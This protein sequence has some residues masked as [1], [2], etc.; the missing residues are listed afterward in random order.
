MRLALAQIKPR[1]RDE[2]LGAAA[3]H[4]QTLI[5][6]LNLV[7]G[8]DSLVFDG[9]SAVYDE[10]GKVIARARGFG[11]ELL[12][13]DLPGGGSLTPLAESAADLD[14]LPAPEARAGDLR[15]GDTVRGVRRRG[16]DQAKREH[17]EDQGGRLE[18]GG[19]C[20][21]VHPST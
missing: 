9:H 12:L 19:L 10:T 6:Y 13:V 21:E 17:R 20:R 15:A 11:E 2:M 7:G 14:A 1:L 5:A 3:R 8:N 16:R 18:H 4:H